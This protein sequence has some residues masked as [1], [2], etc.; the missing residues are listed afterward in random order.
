MKYPSS[1]IITCILCKAEFDLLYDCDEV[2]STTNCKCI[3]KK[4]KI[5]PLD[6]AIRK[7]KKDMKNETH[8]SSTSKISITAK[9]RK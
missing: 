3:K 5:K 1:E 8:F 6:E 7:L 9:T 4:S 2:V